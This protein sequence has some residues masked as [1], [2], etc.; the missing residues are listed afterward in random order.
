MTS[1]AAAPHHDVPACPDLLLF[2]ATICA[3]FQQLEVDYCI[4]RSRPDIWPTQ[5][6][7]VPV[8]RIYG[9]NDAGV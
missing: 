1:A 9:V 5:A 8:V 3:V 7:E 2:C 6:K 4:Q